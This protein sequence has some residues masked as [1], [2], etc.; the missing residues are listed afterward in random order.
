[1]PDASDF[2]PEGFTPI[3]ELIFEKAECRDCGL[4]ALD[5][6]RAWANDHVRQTGHAV[7]L[8]LGYDVRDE[9]WLER[10]SYDRLAEIEA[11]LARKPEVP[12]FR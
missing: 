10:I 4:K 2:L 5:R 11:L 6:V 9:H 3:E 12:D 8:H 1:M 7:Q